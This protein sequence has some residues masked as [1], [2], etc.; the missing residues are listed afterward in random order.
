MKKI[1]ISILLIVQII[2]SAIFAADD[3]LFTDTNADNGF[4]TKVINV[5][6]GNGISVFDNKNGRIMIVDAGSSCLPAKQTVESIIPA[7]FVHIPQSLDMNP[8][9]I[10]VSH[11]DKDHLNWLKRILEHGAIKQN[12]SITVYLGGSF[13]KYLTATEANTLLNALLNRKNLPTIHS[14]SHALTIDDMKDLVTKVDEYRP[15]FIKNHALG[16]EDVDSAVIQ[17]VRMAAQLVQK[18]RPFIVRSKMDGF[19]DF[20]RVVV[21]ILGA[22]A[23]HTPERVYP[24]NSGSISSFISDVSCS[25]GEVVNPDENTNSIILRITFYKKERIIITGDA[26]GIT[27]NRLIKNYLA[28]AEEEALNCDLLIACHHG[29]ITEE[30]N[31]PRWV[32]ATQPKWVVFSAGKYDSYHHPQFDAVWNYAGSP[33]IEVGA[34]SHPV[35]CSRL[36]TRE[37]PSSKEVQTRGLDYSQA[38]TVGTTNKQRWL[39]NILCNRGVYSTH[40]SGTIV[41]NVAFDGATTL[42]VE[43]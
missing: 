38:I 28:A 36:D 29:S 24:V 33:R 22:N 9:T 25:R 15:Q 23:G 30:S 10:I 40:S 5:G 39:E 2:S 13:E 35:L 1:S 42:T 21:E 12:K 17:T 26:T 4:T 27:T 11:P 32:Q 3:D 18:V 8:I 14:L 41:F 43:K 7:M 20:N 37:L 16:Y 19:D 31:N 6:Q 34:S